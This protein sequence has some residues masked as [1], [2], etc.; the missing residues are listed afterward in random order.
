MSGDG[1][2]L[3]F[4]LGGGI[5]I[6]HSLMYISHIHYEK[7]FICSARYDECKTPVQPDDVKIAV[8]NAFRVYTCLLELVLSCH[9][10]K[11]K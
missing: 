8:D 9:T 1:R 6:T 3:G 5:Y 11:R 4:F 2:K 10:K 7:E